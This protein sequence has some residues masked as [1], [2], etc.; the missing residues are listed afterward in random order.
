MSTLK[1]AAPSKFGIRSTSPAPPDL[2]SAA[3]RMCGTA[4]W[5]SKL[6]IQSDTSTVIHSRAGTPESAQ[7]CGAAKRPTEQRNEAMSQSGET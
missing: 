2:R 7:Q 4:E 5:G 1:H 6:A 3:S